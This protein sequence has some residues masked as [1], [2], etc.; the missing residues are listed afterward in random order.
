ML[1]I[2][3][4]FIYKATLN[5]SLLLVKYVQTN[6]PSHGQIGLKGDCAITT[7]TTSLTGVVS[8]RDK[9]GI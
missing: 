6:S 2:V 3:H 1:E 8:R 5:S 7:T 4:K 9:E